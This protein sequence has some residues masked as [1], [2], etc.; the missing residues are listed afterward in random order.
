MMYQFED[1][2]KAD[3]RK[4]KVLSKVFLIRKWSFLWIDPIGDRRYVV[5]YI[6]ALR[7]VEYYMDRMNSVNNPFQKSIYQIKIFYWLSKL[8]KLSYITQFQIPSFTVG[9]GLVIWH[10]GP[11]IINPKTRIGENC[12]LNPMVVI[13]HKNPGEGAPRIGNNVFIGA[14][15]KIIG[16]IHIGNNVTIGQ[17]VVITNDIPDNAIIVS[18]KPRIL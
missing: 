2:V 3:F 14:G 8:R 6:F 4:E 11:I 1:Y 13:G 10:W 7:H 12:T 5:K 9:K 18:Q 15:S 16:N 17:N